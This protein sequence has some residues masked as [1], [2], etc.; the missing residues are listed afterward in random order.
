MK[1][2]IVSWVLLFAQILT[3]LSTVESA[4]Q[5]HRHRHR[6]YKQRFDLNDVGFD[7]NYRNNILL[8]FEKDLNTLTDGLTIKKDVLETTTNNVTFPKVQDFASVLKTQQH[9]LTE[10][11]NNSNEYKN[12]EIKV[13][14][15]IS[16]TLNFYYSQLDD[17]KEG[18]SSL[19]LEILKDID[20]KHG[21]FFQQ[22]FPLKQMIQSASN[23][24]QEL[25]KLMVRQWKIRTAKANTNYWKPALVL[26]NYLNQ[27]DDAT[28]DN[29]GNEKE[30][31]WG[32]VNSEC[33][34]AIV[35]RCEIPY[36]CERTLLDRTPRSQYLLTHQIFQRLL[37]DNANCPNLQ[38]FI[39]DD[40]IYAKLCT[41]AYLEAQYLDLLDVPINQRDLFAELVGLCGYLGYTNFLRVD[42]LHRILS[43][44][45]ES[46]SGCYIV[47]PDTP[48]G[49]ISTDMPFKR[50]ATK[51]ELQ[52]GIVDTNEECLPHL[53]AVALTAI[54][55]F[56]DYL[57]S[58][59]VRYGDH[60]EL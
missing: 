49:L 50:T 32:K 11:P 15:S 16:R 57:Q 13:V 40:D 54:T 26:Q 3:Q 21:K 23:S 6:V 7:L 1:W 55:T 27:I 17:I 34:D 36:I 10:I 59:Q 45:S 51:K 5:R 14:D 48:V 8:E 30:G 38:P 29:I 28:L 53:T 31:L 60:L 56:W 2:Y 18:D 24:G 46:D 47:D 20:A 9:L 44:Q 52:N 43:W 19:S 4:R 35:S 42:W 22:N 39:S 25:D 58:N 37:I 41:K 33:Q 12:L